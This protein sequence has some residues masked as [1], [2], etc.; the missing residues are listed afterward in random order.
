V[1]VRQQRCAFLIARGMTYKEAAQ[2]VGIHTRNVEAWMSPSAPDQSMRRYVESERERMQGIE[3]E[4]DDVCRQAL[5]AIKRDG[6]PDW[7][8]RL[9]AARDLE[10]AAA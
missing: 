7:T 2:A 3:P 1:N 5:G 4:A 6:S 9:I 8:A 10:D